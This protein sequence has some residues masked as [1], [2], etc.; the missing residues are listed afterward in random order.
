MSVTPRTPQPKQPKKEGRSYVS[1]IIFLLILARPLW[2]IVR[3]ITPP[4]INS[5]QILMIVAGVVALGVVTIIALRAR[6]SRLLTSRSLTSYEQP[7]SKSKP[8]TMYSPPASTL[9]TQPRQMSSTLPRTP[10][11]EPAITG[12]VILVGIVLAAAIAGVIALIM[13]LTP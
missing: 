3:S 6:D 13:A 7:R 4:T 10:T 2:G 5:Q 12:T 9:P 1:W 8:P 11:F